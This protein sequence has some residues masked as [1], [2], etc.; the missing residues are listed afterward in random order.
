MFLSIC[1]SS[2]CVCYSK[3][4]RNI[5]DNKSC[6]NMNQV[7]STNMAHLR[8]QINSNFLKNQ[9]KQIMYLIMTIFSLVLLD[10]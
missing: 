2:E 10:S 1:L 5:S 9:F 6:N 4:D 3:K 7:L 8:K